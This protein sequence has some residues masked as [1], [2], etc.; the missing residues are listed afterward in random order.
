MRKFS[1]LLAAALLAVGCGDNVVSSNPSGST[2]G[3]S[4]S[5]G[6]DSGSS[7][8]TGATAGTDSGSTGGDSTG[9]TGA[10]SAGDSGSSG[11]TTGSTDP[12]ATYPAGGGHGVAIGQVMSNVQVT[13]YLNTSLGVQIDTNSPWAPFDLEAVRMLTDANGNHFRYM[14]LDLGAGWCVPCNNEGDQYGLNGA[15]SAK[16]AQWLSKGGLYVQVLV[17]WCEASAENA[18]YCK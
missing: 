10:T 5:T 15:D 13:G 9:S 4:T 16:I 1:V 17:Q 7:G 8:S 3:S 14:L 11:G 18:A 12:R 2:S 6:G